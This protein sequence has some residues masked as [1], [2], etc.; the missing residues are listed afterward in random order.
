MAVSR[1][2]EKK[3]YRREIVLVIVG[4]VL[5]SVPT[6]I[7][8]YIQSRTQLQQL[9]IDKRVSALRDYAMA[10]NRFA[11]E[12]VPKFEK[13]EKRI[14]G[15]Q[16][17]YSK[18]QMTFE[19]IDAE[20]DEELMGIEFQMN[21]VMADVNVNRMVINSLFQTEFAQLNLSQEPMQETERGKE[22]DDQL[23]KDIKER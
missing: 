3:D 22:P 19:E 16:D 10:F 12:I 7:S 1:E 6:L 23:L 21:S 8:T 4:A 15:L 2:K 17:K 13:L 9:I 5:A 14:E 20:I 18:K 11:T